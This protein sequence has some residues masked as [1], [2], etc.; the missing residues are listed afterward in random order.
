MELPRWGVAEVSP[1]GVGSSSSRVYL[2][3]E[4]T[5]S[6]LFLADNPQTLLVAVLVF[7]I[8]PNDIASA[9]FLREDERDVGIQRLRG[10]E[11]GTGNKERQEPT[12]D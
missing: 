2:W 6:S 8:L 3:V 7:L 9:S 11:H 10:V 5:P 1:L 12:A 4:G